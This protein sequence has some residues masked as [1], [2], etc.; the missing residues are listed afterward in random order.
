MPLNESPIHASL[1]KRFLAGLFDFTINIT[2]L[3]VLELAITLSKPNRPEMIFTIIS[4]LFLFFYYIWSTYKTGA[5]RGKKYFNLK[6]VN[7]F[8]P[9][10]LSFMTVLIREVILKPISI[11]SL[12]YLYLKFDPDGDPIAFQDHYTD[13][14]V[15]LNPP[16]VD[17]AIYSYQSRGLP[18]LALLIPVFIVYSLIFLATPIPLSR[19]KTELNILGLQIDGLTGNA[20]KGF[21]INN[22][23]SSYKDSVIRMSDIQFRL[24]IAEL[25]LR[26]KISIPNFNISTLE[27]NK[28]LN[29]QNANTK[30]VTP[31]ELL[32]SL[33][34]PTNFEIKKITSPNF[35]IYGKSNNSLAISNISKNF[36]GLLNI[37]NL[38]IETSFFN[39]SA[40]EASFNSTNNMMKLNS[41]QLTLKPKMHPR[42]IKDI[43][44]NLAAEFNIENPELAIF[45]L[46]T[47]TDEIRIHQTEKSFVMQ[48]KNFNIREWLQLPWPINKLSL[49]YYDNVRFSQIIKNPNLLLTQETEVQLHGRKFSIHRDTKKPNARNIASLQSGVPASAACE[50]TLCLH[51]SD[52]SFS[53]NFDLQTLLSDSVGSQPLKIEDA[54]RN[55]SYSSSSE[56]LAQVY[57]NKTFSNLN[58]NEK[59]VVQQ[60]QALF[61]LKPSRVADESYLRELK[62]LNKNNRSNYQALQSGRIIL[63]NLR[64]DRS[65]LGIYRAIAY[66]KSV[67]DCD[68]ILA[69]PTDLFT[70]MIIQQPKL[71]SPIHLSLASCAKDPHVALQL[72]TIA[73]QDK[74]LDSEGLQL[75]GKIYFRQKKYSAALDIFNRLNRSGSSEVDLDHLVQI[76][77]KMGNKQT[78]L[79]VGAKLK[80]KIKQAPEIKRNISSETRHFLKL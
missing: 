49:N 32:A 36:D 33:V 25:I 70:D 42:L 80:S 21:K 60:E 52:R 14:R 20:V 30:K 2:F 22:L 1:G 9:N 72:L 40:Q 51:Y 41:S 54:S 76:H 31:P 19:L 63:A 13:T 65:A 11:F 47:A 39:F 38:K 18:F 56:L 15:I 71:K 28:N 67:G 6:V 46:Q 78:A 79:N 37:G 50:S 24:D 17:E 66:L 74:P 69:L 35:I 26:Q 8:N 29:I 61:D 55:H 4:L 68:S 58:E 45:N 75:L 64:Q 3:A 27:I 48:I 5:T 10:D 57:F 16:S 73:T 34:A 53:M 59:S 7:Q 44:F 12:G 62:N 77:R 43:S 23:Q